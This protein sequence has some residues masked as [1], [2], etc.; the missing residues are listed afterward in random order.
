M[1]TE[2]PAPGRLERRTMTAEQLR[3]LTA[4]GRPRMFAILDACDTPRV[5]QLANQRPD[6]AICLYKG[7]AMARHGAIAPWLFQTDGEIFDWIL[8]EAWEEPW[9]L[10]LTAEGEL[11]DLRNHFRRFLLVK[12]P[13]NEEVYFRFYDPRVL[14]T[15]L[16]TCTDE[17]LERFFGPVTQYWAQPRVGAD[18]SILSR[19]ASAPAPAPAP[20]AQGAAMP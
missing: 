13:E 10:L 5:L 4:L 20:A 16:P 9:G 18:L 1:T 2:A 11:E 17:E 3:A 7:L 14:C 12:T 19:P 15:F 8:A 6:R